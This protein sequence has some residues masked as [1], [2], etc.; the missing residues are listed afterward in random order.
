MAFIRGFG[1]WLPSRIVTNEE[2]A[3]R[4]GKE[5]SWIR[6]VSGIEQRRWGAPEDTVVAMGARA[7]NNC[8]ETSGATKEEIGLVIVSTGSHGNRFPGAAAEIAHALGMTGVPAIDVPVA[9]A[10]SLFGL[11]LASQLVEKYRNILVIASEKMSSVIDKDPSTAILFGDGA[12]ACLVSAD[13]GKMRIIDSV[14][15]SDGSYAGE[16]MLP[17]DGP[18]LM[19]GMSVIMQASRKVPAV[20]LEVLEKQRRTAAEIGLF[21]MHQANQ[22]LILRIA[23]SLGVASEKFYSN[24]NRCGNT[25]SASMLIAA[26]ECWTSAKSICFAAFG[27]GYHWGALLAEAE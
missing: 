10:G 23:K 6:D 7:G 4:V 27:A 17:L 13:K 25:S 22:N 9:S 24:I 19:N 11:T 8:L 15:H 16:L 3:E 1:S 20:I 5:A 18:I 21:V 2:I 14:L 12:G 26:S